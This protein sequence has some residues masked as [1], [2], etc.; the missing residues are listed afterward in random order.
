M[1]S[2]SRDTYTSDDLFNVPEIDVFPSEIEALVTSVYKATIAGIELLDKQEQAKFK[3]CGI[4]YEPGGYQER[5]WWEDQIQNMKYHAGNMCLVSLISI[6]DHWLARRQRQG[7]GRK[8]PFE[9][10]TDDLGVGPLTLAEFK[11]M[12]IAR[13]SIIHQGG[14]SRFVYRNVAYTVNDRFL[15]FDAFADGQVAIEE[16]LLAD[17]SNKIKSQ[18]DIWNR[19]AQKKQEIVD[20]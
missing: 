18:V 3:A 4:D 13:N 15:N 10:L 8:S 7:N 2:R 14:R 17:L 6:F 16:S 19:E 12:R 1:D 5:W 9:K 20:P 11:E